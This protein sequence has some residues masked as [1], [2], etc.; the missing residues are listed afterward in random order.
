MSAP[1]THRRRSAGQLQEL[2]H[3]MAP[4]LADA[5]AEEV[6]GW[7]A[8]EFGPGLAVA[9]SMADAVLP[10]LAS[11]ALPG[12]DVVFLD[13]GYH[14]EETLQTR[15]EVAARLPVRV[16]SIEP[17]RSV[18]EQDAE[19]GPDLFATDPGA[20]CRMRKV[21][22]LAGAL[23]GY[24]AWATGLRRVDGPGRADTPVLTWDARHGLVKV[25]P[26]AAWSDEQV[27]AYVTEH[28]LPVNALIEQGYP[29]IGCGP[30]T[31]RPQ[32]GADP[33][34]GRWAGFAKT[35]CGLHT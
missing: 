20:C 1:S 31:L 35:E 29:S 5:P 25:N 10:H 8:R 18:P 16:L 13:T 17:V 7:A 22:P 23:A 4:V 21:E 12:V 24:E 3:Q 32:E 14:F 2:V 34:S 26:V 15:D 30:C 28:D 33:R 9:G 27:E 11:V 6:L 19:F